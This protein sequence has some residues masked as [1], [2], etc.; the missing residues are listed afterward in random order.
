[1]L[2][3]RTRWMAAANGGDE[4]RRPHYLE[5]FEG[6]LLEACRYDLVRVYDINR[7]APDEVT[8]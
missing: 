3:G 5:S 7:S 4:N 2:I 8:I 1:M 6:P